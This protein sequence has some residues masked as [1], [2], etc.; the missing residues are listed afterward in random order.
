M[1]RILGRRIQS[2]GL[3]PAAVRHLQEQ[4]AALALEVS[5]GPREIEELRRARANMSTS[6][7]LKR[8]AKADAAIVAKIQR[9][10]ECQ[11]LIEEID[12][13]LETFLN[14]E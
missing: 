12:R 10:E 3:H 13:Q 11:R 4:R 2:T 6:I 1:T 8:R 9:V 14:L 5:R 7:T